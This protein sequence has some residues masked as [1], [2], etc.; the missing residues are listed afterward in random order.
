[1]RQVIKEIGIAPNDIPVLQKMDWATLISARRTVAPKMN[2]PRHDLVFGPPSGPGSV[3]MVG[4]TPTLDAKTIN[5]K[6]FEDAAPD[7]SKDV[8]ML[9]GSVSEETMRYLS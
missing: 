4:W 1:A 5:I 6:S 8:P 9:F 7:V 3:A 2:P